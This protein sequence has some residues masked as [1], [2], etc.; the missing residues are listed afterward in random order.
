MRLTYD[1]EADALYLTVSTA[2]VDTTREVA[3]NVT[4]DLDAAGQL[5]GVEVLGA[6][7]PVI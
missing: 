5:V 7:M 1:P 2:A 4:I 6:L 3:P